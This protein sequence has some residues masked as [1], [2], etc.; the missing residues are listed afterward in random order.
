MHLTLTHHKIWLYPKPVDFRSSIDGLS[1][2]IMSQGLPVQGGI[3]VF[4]NTTR[5]KLKLL[6]WHVNGFILLYKRLERGKFIFCRDNAN[7]YSV[8]ERQLSWLLAGL[9]WVQMSRFNELEFDDFT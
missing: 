9:D 6:V 4:H 7:H 5:D 8:N 3:F 1:A 2:L